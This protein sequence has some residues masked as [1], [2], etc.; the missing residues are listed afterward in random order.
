[1][2][3]INGVRNWATDMVGEM[4]GEADFPSTWA[5]LFHIWVSILLEGWGL[6]LA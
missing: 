4:S 1:M 5:S 6:S 3:I 2:G